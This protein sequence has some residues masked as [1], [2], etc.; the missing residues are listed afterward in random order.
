MRHSDGH[1]RINA[2]SLRLG[3]TGSL[4]DVGRTRRKGRQW[5]G[6]ALKWSWPDPTA[7][8]TRVVALTLFS[9]CGFLTG[10][11]GLVKFRFEIS[12]ISTHFA[13]RAAVLGGR[14]GPRGMSTAA[15]RGRLLSL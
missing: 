4:G 10:R 2:T 15:D 6:V 9:F 13:R 14:A 12:L 8:F 3:E 1:N 7:R 5:V 11:V